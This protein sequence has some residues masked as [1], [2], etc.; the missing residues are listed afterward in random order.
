MSRSV[1]KKKKKRLRNNPLNTKVMLGTYF[2]CLLLTFLSTLVTY[3]L[4]LLIGLRVALSSGNVSSYLENGN[5]LDLHSGEALPVMACKYIKQLLDRHFTKALIAILLLSAVLLLL[6]WLASKRNSYVVAKF[7]AACL[8]SA[9]ILMI[10]VPALCLFLGL[11]KSA[12]L[13]NTQNTLLF[14]G[15]LKSS[16]FILIAF[17]V[18]ILAFA[19][20]SE[21]IAASITR[22]R[23]QLYHRR[24][25][26]PDQ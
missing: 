4:W 15:Y 22:K 1:Q 17:G 11:H 14:Q 24:T 18:V 25:L 6:L 19:F 26:D 12:V 5:F 3:A 13:I 2:L 7:I 21:F 16:L 10:L 20:I 23:K 9:G 8:C